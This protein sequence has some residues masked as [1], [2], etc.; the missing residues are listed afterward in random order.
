MEEE[1]TSLAQKKNFGEKSNF[2][3]KIVFNEGNPLVVEETKELK[4]G[5]LN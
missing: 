1:E 3:V 5:Q 2:F 4:E